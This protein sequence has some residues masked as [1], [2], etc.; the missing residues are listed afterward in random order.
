MEIIGE[1]RITGSGANKK[2]VVGMSGGVD[3]AVT[4]YLLKAS[5]FDVAGVTLRTWENAF[6]EDSR[7]CEIDAAKETADA[8]GIPLYVQNC[9]ADFKEHVSEPFVKEYLCARTPNPCVEC[10]RYVKWAWLLKMADR[11]GADWV[12][13]GH[14]AFVEKL[15]NGRWTIRQAASAGKDQTY[16]LYRLT[17]EQLSRTLMPLGALNKDEVRGIAEK[18]GLPVAHKA[19]SQEICFVADGSDY[20]DY[21]EEHAE[22]EIPGPGP[23]VDEDGKVL[24]THKGIIHYTVGQR[25]GLGLPL[26]Y[27]AYVKEIRPDTNE[28]V[29]SREEALYSRQITCDRINFLSISDILPGEEVSAAV[30]VRYHHQGT[31]AVIRRSG[32]DELTISFREPV[33]AATPGQS[34][35]F[36]DEKCCIIGGGRITE[37]KEG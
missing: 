34:A 18:A 36:Y 33:R 17:Q 22:T 2:V 23:F 26:G 4:A 25:K 21:I 5:G 10:N 35:V 27:H 37:K 12:A 19:D 28:V 31:P 7:C 30:R 8:L 29:I 3:S 16:V 11:L 15:E 24:G 14:Y 6:G 9:A 32:E 1:N 13:T 20:A